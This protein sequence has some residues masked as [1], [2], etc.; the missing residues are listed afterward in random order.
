MTGGYPYEGAAEETAKAVQAIAKV[1]GQ[2]I[3][4]TNSLGRFL[5]KIIGP[6]LSNLGGAFNDWAWEFRYKNALRIADR[7]EA[8]HK[9]RELFGKT[10]PIPPR[11]GIPLIEKAVLEDD[12]TLAEMWAGLIANATDPSRAV[13]PRRTLIE[14]LGS[15]EPLDALVLQ[16]IASYEIRYPDRKV[17]GFSPAESSE[18]AQWPNFENLAEELELPSNAVILALDNLERL[19]LVRDRISNDR[20]T[21]FPVAASHSFATIDLTETGRL[22]LNACQS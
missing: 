11:L 22:L 2:T 19:A 10:V 21:S 18:R 3:D 17:T 14:L 12:Q 20:D 1:A 5:H 8:I 6:G 4:T 7:V 15:L 16:L 9:E 13:V